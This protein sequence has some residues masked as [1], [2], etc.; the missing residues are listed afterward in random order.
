ML[1][2]L[3]IFGFCISISARVRIHYAAFYVAILIAI[4]V[5]LAPRCNFES[6]YKAGK[7]AAST[8]RPRIYWS[9]CLLA[10]IAIAHWLVVLKPEAGTDALSMHLA[11]A[12]DMAHRHVLTLDFPQFVWGL[13]PMGADFCYALAHIIGGE[14][15]ARLL[16]LAML[17]GVALLV[18]RVARMWLPAEAALLF[19]S[20]S[21]SSPMTQ[22]VTGSMMVENFVAAMSLGAG[23]AAWRFH[24]QPSARQLSLFA[25]LLGTA[26][27]W[28]IG[29]ITLAITLIP[30]AIFSTARNW[31]KLAKPRLAVLMASTL[32]VVPAILPYAVAF[33][34]SGNPI[35]PFANDTFHSPY[36]NEVLVDTRFIEPLTAATLFRITF[37]TN[38]YFEGLPG[39]FGFQYL[40]LAPLCI[41]VFARLRTA[42]ARSAAVTGFAGFVLIAASTPNA[43]YFYPALPFL[44]LGFAAAIGATRERDSRLYVTALSSLAVIIGLNIWFLPVSSTYHRDFVPKPL[45]SEQGRIAYRQQAA[46]IRDVVN[47]VNHQGS[48]VMFTENSEFAGATVP[49]YL[50]HWHNFSFNKQVQACRKPSDIH[51]LVSSLHIRQFVSPIRHDPFV[52]ESAPALMKYLELCGERAFQAGGFLALSIHPECEARLQQLER[53]PQEPR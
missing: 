26:V 51:Q 18:Y 44:T 10:Y 17:C 50:N 41:V 15:A 23:V 22:L 46:P 6:I 47:Y 35:Y 49:V 7:I 3:A 28:K 25:L 16:N 34:R 13:M 9:G 12:F 36:I 8:A 27:G 45:F 2:G 53:G 39:S 1:A 40:L 24:E 19:S 20:A 32:F 31:T 5:L 52:V 43:R 48:A 30:F 14:Y 11:I 37:E 29:A 33:V 4:L 38:R 21:L 42:M